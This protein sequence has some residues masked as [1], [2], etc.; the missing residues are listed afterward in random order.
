MIFHEQQYRE[1][2]AKVGVG[3]NDNV[4]SS[5]ESYVSYL[6]SVSK[7][8]NIDISPSTVADEDD[9]Q[10]IYQRLQKKR[11]E[12]TINNYRSAMRQYAEMVKDLR[13][14]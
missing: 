1:Y 12:K 3:R 10:D 4:A 14:K 11:S 9:I 8:L 13:L 2:L 6:R 7:I 5:I